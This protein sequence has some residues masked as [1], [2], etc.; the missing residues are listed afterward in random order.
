MKELR[1]VLLLWEKPIRVRLA[2]VTRSL[3]LPSVAKSSE[4]S[5]KGRVTEVSLPGRGAS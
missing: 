5:N 4:P 3:P 2:R 1:R